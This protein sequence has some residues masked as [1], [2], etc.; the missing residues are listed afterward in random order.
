MPRFLRLV[1]TVV[2]SGLV[3]RWLV[4]NNERAVAGLMLVFVCGEALRLLSIHD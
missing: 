2:V 4:L 1:R 3:D